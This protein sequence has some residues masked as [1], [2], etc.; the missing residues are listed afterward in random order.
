MNRRVLQRWCFYSGYWVQ[1]LALKIDLMGVESCWTQFFF[2]SI[3]NYFSCMVP[4]FEPDRTSMKHQ[5]MK[6]DHLKYRQSAVCR[7]LI[8]MCYSIQALEKW[9]Y[10]ANYIFFIWIYDLYQ[11]NSVAF[12]SSKHSAF[13]CTKCKWIYHESVRMC[14]CVYS[15]TC[16]PI[17]T[18]NCECEAPS[19]NLMSGGRIFGRKFWH[20]SYIT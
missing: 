6:R 20:I 9:W 11:W 15:F 7:R 16:A 8:L 1:L 19:V 5:C 4:A 13:F 3:L 17:G 18:P 12:Y 10:G 14:Q 2:V